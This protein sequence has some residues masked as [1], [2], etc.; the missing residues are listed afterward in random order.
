MVDEAAL[1]D[2]LKS[3]HLSHAALDVFA[4]EPYRGPLSAL[5]NI[6]LTAHIGAMA[7]ESR[8]QME[9]EAVANALEVLAGRPPNDEVPYP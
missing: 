4:Q 2:A 3:R 8:I 6:T 9:L 7:Q 5:S 1:A